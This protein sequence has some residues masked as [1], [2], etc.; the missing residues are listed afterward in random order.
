MNQTRL[1]EFTPIESESS[2]WQVDS[3]FMWKVLIVICGMI[4]FPGCN[5]DFNSLKGEQNS[6]K[7]EGLPVP[8]EEPVLTLDAS[9]FNEIMEVDG[10]RVIQNPDNPLILVNKEFSLSQ[11]YVP[12]DL[13]RPNIAFSFGDEDIEKSYLRKEAALA[14][15]EMFGDAAEVGIELFAVSGYRSYERQ[16]SNFQNNVN[17]LGED[18]AIR[19]SA[20][21]GNSEHQTGLAMDISSR[22]ADLL[23]TQKFGETVEGKWLMDNAHHYGFILRYPEGLEDITGYIYE[24]WHYRYVGVEIATEIKDRQ[25]TLEEYFNIVKRI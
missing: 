5:N 21:P 6:I 22:S 23:L 20:S 19:V 1:G 13:V 2:K 9:F 7:E 12:Q 11:E 17:R 25:I 10:K 15:E 14:L 4:I 18:E 3:F 8:A 16:N 24:P